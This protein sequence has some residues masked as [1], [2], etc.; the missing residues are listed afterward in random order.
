M[1]RINTIKEAENHSERVEIWK[2]YKIQVKVLKFHIFS[3][4]Q[5]RWS[6]GTKIESIVICYWPKWMKILNSRP[7]HVSNQSNILF[8]LPNTPAQSKIKGE[9][10][11]KKK[12]KLKK[13]KLPPK[14]KRIIIS[15]VP[16]SSFFHSLYILLPSTL[17]HHYPN[18]AQSL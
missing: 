14:K 9:K 15:T 6:P 7:H 4:N 5:I 3:V 16:S 12:D 2:I 17:R 11:R 8:K 10:R 13:K 18:C 1:N